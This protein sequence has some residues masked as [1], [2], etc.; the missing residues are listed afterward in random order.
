MS[1][2]NAS[3]LVL[4]GKSFNFYNESENSIY[5]CSFQ[6]DSI[7]F[8]KFSNI[9]P[10]Q[11]ANRTPRI[12]N[13]QNPI[14]DIFILHDDIKQISENDIIHQL[15]LDYLISKNF[16][17]K[18]I[19]HKHI[20]N[21]LINKISDNLRINFF[22]VYFKK[23]EIL[24]QSNCKN[25]NSDI[26]INSNF[27]YE[28]RCNLEEIYNLENFKSQLAEFNEEI[29]YFNNVIPTITISFNRMLTLY[30][31]NKDSL[32]VNNIKSSYTFCRSMDF[33]KIKEIINSEVCDEY[34]EK[35]KKI[36][37]KIRLDKLQNSKK[38][39]P[40]TIKGIKIYYAKK[41]GGFIAQIPF[42][43]SPSYITNSTPD[44]RFIISYLITT[45]EINN[46]IYKLE[47]LFI[48]SL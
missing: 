31:V 18:Q 25:I 11:L 22:S 27:I 19:N 15:S 23:I 26:Q 9:D 48:L 36:T 33:D 17:I 7:L 6:N 5:K 32:N 44:T 2:K 1:A 13:N 46:F 28:F 37:K 12:Y 10:K 47:N 43:N 39:T 3:D 8:S 40:I 14:E 30:N 20:Y 16:T 4:N 45:N 21:A 42:L 35:I 34:I 41:F 24:I 38:I 29:N